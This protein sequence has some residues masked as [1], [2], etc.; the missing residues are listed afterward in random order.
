MS[1]KAA[2][3]AVAAPTERL[4][5]ATKLAFGA[6][7]LAPAI[8]TIIPSFFQFFFLTNIA[9][10]NPFVAGTIRAILTVWDAVNDPLVGWLSDRTRSRLGRRRPWI[11]YGAVPFGVIYA[12]QWVVPPFGEAGKFIY[13]LVV[14]LLFNMAFT[15]V[16]VPYT[17]LTAELTNDYD[18]RTSLN[19]YRFAFSVGGSLIAGALHPMI[20]EQYSNPTTGYLVSG[21]VWGGLCILPFLWCV[22][23]VRERPLPDTAEQQLSIW[24]QFRT[25][26][27]NQPY[28]FVIGIYLFSWLA[29]Q[30]TSA[31]IVPYVT[32]WLQ[33]TDLIPVSL[34][35]VQGSAFVW[36]FLWSVI[37]RRIGK[38]MVYILGMCFWVLVQA[39]LFFVQPDQA[40]LAL[41]L[42]VLAGIGISTAYIVPWS[43]LPD[44]VDIDELQSGQRREGV[45]YGLIVLLQKFGLAIGQFLMGLLLAQAGYI[46]NEASNVSS[47]V[48]VQPESALFAMRL[49]I[50]PVPAIMLIIGMVIAFYY[51][52][53]KQR[54]AEIQAELAARRAVP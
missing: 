46:S 12:L 25:A 29:V 39:L 5:L 34:L 18:E 33:R 37:S 21:M 28:L 36:L 53:D 38:K 41:G 2:T 49:Q 3:S 17:A 45:F 13:Y 48:I 26:L 11:L 27:S 24:E 51:P 47:E 9:G 4:P 42:A 20:V 52:I 32:F 16:N 14:G 50:G 44:A 40:N 43:M 7:D 8:A 54:H 23:G 15:I 35:A 22:A 10:L 1:N 6:G 30:F 19:A 31:I